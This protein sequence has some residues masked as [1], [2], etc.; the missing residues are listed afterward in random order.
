MFLKKE[1]NLN[2]IYVLHPE[3]SDEVDLLKKQGILYIHKE[4]VASSF[5]L[6]IVQIED[7]MAKLQ[8]ISIF[9]KSARENDTSHFTVECH[10]EIINPGGIYLL[11]VMNRNTKT[12]CEIWNMLTV[13]TPEQRSWPYFSVFIV[14]IEHILQFF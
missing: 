14:N 13:Q 4:K 2:T 11:K 5:K 10:F 9:K 1:Y 7:L 12:H 3:G 8:E 6:Q